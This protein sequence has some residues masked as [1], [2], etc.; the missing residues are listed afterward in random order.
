MKRGAKGG[1]SESDP[2]CG[3]QDS[4]FVPLEFKMVLICIVNCIVLYCI[5]MICKECNY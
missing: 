2:T 5:V 4:S 3:V 1:V